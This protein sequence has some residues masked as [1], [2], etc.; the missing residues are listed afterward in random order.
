MALATPPNFTSTLS[1]C[2]KVVALVI[3]VK[4][5]NK[6]S[7]YLSINKECLPFF[8]KRA[9]CIYAA[10]FRNTVMQHLF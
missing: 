3:I 4:F 7:I 6:L 9:K 1:T 10:V 2:Y 8:K 5:G